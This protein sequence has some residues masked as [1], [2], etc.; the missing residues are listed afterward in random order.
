MLE[1]SLEIYLEIY[2]KDL[3]LRILGFRVPEWIVLFAKS[4]SLVTRLHAWNQKFSLAD[5]WEGEKALSVCSKNTDFWASSQFV[6]HILTMIVWKKIFLHFWNSEGIIV[7]ES[8]F[9]SCKNGFPQV[10]A[11]NCAHI[12]IFMAKNQH[13]KK[14]VF[15]N[16]ENTFFWEK[17]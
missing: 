4:D 15:L 13:F 1:C 5:L 10:W 16:L 17:F 2:L 9:L 6:P 3:R 7:V 11:Q 8:I 14:L 12:P